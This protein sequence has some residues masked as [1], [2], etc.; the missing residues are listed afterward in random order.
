MRYMWNIRTAWQQNERLHDGLLGSDG[1]E[2]P[3]H[4]RYNGIVDPNLIQSLVQIIIRFDEKK[5]K[6][7]LFSP[8]DLLI[9]MF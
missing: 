8:F 3:F 9:V 6:I 5:T 2:R 4:T 7:K 1:F